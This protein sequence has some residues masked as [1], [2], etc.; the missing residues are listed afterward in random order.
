MK[1]ITH[2]FDGDKRR[3]REFIEHIDVA[4]QLVHPNKHDVLWKF[5]KTKITGDARSRLMIR[6]L[7]HTWE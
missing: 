7:T 3:L 1:F 6:D 4:F 2:P 5:V